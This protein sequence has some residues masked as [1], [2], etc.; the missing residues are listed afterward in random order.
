[1]NCQV[2]G[3]GGNY[4]QELDRIIFGGSG[5]S[6]QS[7]RGIY[8]AGG[9]G[10]PGEKGAAKLAG[11]DWYNNDVEY[12]QP[13]KLIQSSEV[14]SPKPAGGRTGGSENNEFFDWLL[15]V[16]NREMPPRR[17]PDNGFLERL[18]GIENNEGKPKDNS[19]DKDKDRDGSYSR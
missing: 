16:K 13:P 5:E 19:Q 8:G 10:I 14:T 1:M 17:K 12:G 6:G 2:A 11:Y 18:T 15:D 4:G 9:E 3:Q 7:G